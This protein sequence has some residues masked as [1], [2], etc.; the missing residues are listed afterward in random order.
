[1]TVRCAVLGLGRL[2]YHHAKNLAT[3]QI[4]GAELITVCDPM[5]GRAAE[6]AQEFG[7]PNCTR[8][9]QEVFEDS[10]ID[11]VVIVT[12]TSTHANLIKQAAKAGKQIFVEKPLTQ[13]LT[14]AQEIINTIS[15][16]NVMCQVGFMR[17]FDPAYAE[18]K[19][20]IVAG[21][22]GEPIYFK[23]ITRD[24]GSPPEEFIKHSG[25]MFLDVSIHDYDIARYLMNSEIISVS[26]QGKV[27][28]NGFMEKY[29]DVDQ[30]IS[31]IEFES[32]AAGD[33]EASRNSPY[34]HDI[35]TEVIGTEGSIFIGTLRNQNITLLNSK[36]SNYEIIPD[37]QTRF[38]DAYRLELVD[39]ADCI[40][41][42][43]RPK[44]TEFDGK[45]N[46]EIAIA[47]TEAFDSGTTVYLNNQNIAVKS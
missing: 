34:G 43:N 47:A 36:G 20:R 27:L 17:R 37:F 19:K 25:R 6:V 41:T 8:S 10:E 5:K 33:I 18:A 38:H 11:A 9:P 23:G 1:M 30:A 14:E 42:G 12:P 44:V 13:N 3:H 2:G 35:R 40:R 31:Y 32:G 7:L 21:D 45:I 4:S 22:I 29:N 46:L 26:A 24:A 15:E 39:F 16:H 28:R